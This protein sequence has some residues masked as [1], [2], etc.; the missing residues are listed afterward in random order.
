[1]PFMC[2]MLKHAIVTCIYNTQV[3]SHIFHM[4]PNV[5]SHT[6]FSHVTCCH[7][8]HNMYVNIATHIFHMSHAATIQTQHV[9]KYSHT[10]FHMSHAATTDTTC[11][12][13]HTHLNGT[14]CLQRVQR[15]YNAF[16]WQSSCVIAN[17]ARKT[18]EAICS[19]L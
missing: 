2:H 15:A 14:T 10:H 11:K 7:H 12:C 17:N 1:M 6:H 16:T 4:S 19:R 13:S 18:A 3:Y 5:Y 9:R 8:R